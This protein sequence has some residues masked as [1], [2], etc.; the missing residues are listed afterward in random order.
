VLLPYI[1]FFKG[2][3]TN[4]SLHWKRAFNNIQD[5]SHVGFLSTL[6]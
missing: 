4:L 3:P 6:N 2:G 1:T 5:P